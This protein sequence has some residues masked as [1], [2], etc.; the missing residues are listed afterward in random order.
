MTILLY[1]KR[2]P[3]F[4]RFFA[5]TAYITAA[6][7]AAGTAHAQTAGGYS[8]DGNKI[9]DPSGQVIEVRGV[10]WF[11]M[12]EGRGAPDGLN[13]SVLADMVAAIKGAGFNAIRIPFSVESINSP[14]PPT[15]IEPNKDM[16]N[17]DAIE[18]LNEVIDAAAAEGLLILLDVHRTPNGSSTDGGPPAG[19]EQEWIATWEKVATAFAD[20]PNVLGADLY[21]EP[22]KLCWGSDECDGDIGTDWAALAT[23]AGNAV[24]EIAPNWLIFVEGVTEYGGAATWWGGNLEGAREEPVELAVPNKLVYSPHEYGPEVWEQEWFKEPSARYSEGEKLEEAEFISDEIKETPFPEVMPYVWEQFW[25]YLHLEGTAPISVGEFGGKLADPI[26]LEWFTQL[27]AFMTEHKMSGFFWSWNSNSGD[28]GGIVKDI[29]SK[30]LELEEEKLSIMA[31]WLGQATGFSAFAPG[32]MPDITPGETPEDDGNGT[33]SDAGAGTGTDAP[34]EEPAGGGTSSEGDDAAAAGGGDDGCPDDGAPTLGVAGALA[35]EDEENAGAAPAGGGGD[36]YAKALDY[37]MRF[38]YSQQAGER[39][40][41]SD[42]Y[43]TY[44]ADLVESGDT[45]AAG[46]TGA[47]GYFDAGDHVKFV[48]PMAMAMYEL[49]AG[50]QRFA[51]GYEAAGQSDEIK[52]QLDHAYAFFSTLLDGDTL[53]AQVGDADADH[54]YW[55]GL[56]GVPEASGKPITVE[57]GGEAADMAAHLA[58]F[59]FRYGDTEKGLAFL[60]FA[61]DSLG[62]YKVP[63]FYETNHYQDELMLANLEAHHATGEETYLTRA[64][65]LSEEEY[66]D[67]G[68]QVTVGQGG[69]WAYDWDSAHAQA[70]LALLEY[71]PNYVA[72]AEEMLSGT[73]EKW[74][75]LEKVGGVMPFRLEWGAARYASNMASVMLQFGALSEA[76]AAYREQA[77]E[78]IDFVLGVHPEANGLSLMTGADQIIDGITQSPMNPHHR[79]A[80]MA[81]GEADQNKEGGGGDVLVGA[82]VG[83]P[84]PGQAYKDETGDYIMNEV[85]VDYNSGFTTALA[86]LTEG[87]DA[88]PTTPPAG[89]ATDDTEPDAGAETPAGA[90]P[91]APDTTTGDTGGADDDTSADGGAADDP[92]APQ[93][94]PPPPPEEVFDGCIFTDSAG[95]SYRSGGRGGASTNSPPNTPRPGRAEEAG[96]ESSPWVNAGPNV[97]ATAP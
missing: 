37:S 27:M 50:S 42:G 1:L 74:L 7:T 71:A 17:M 64:L 82:L 12:E 40:A 77:K 75:E 88:P 63:P 8:T 89:G 41:A 44:G 85:A 51:G 92:C 18:I 53:L 56:D 54:A 15:G 6:L 35:E 91:D 49:L 14:S 66:D 26:E 86:A 81:D 36:V 58:A 83:G 28:T 79:R 24:L 78:I 70:G 23:E 10:N 57:R 29:F 13:V 67:N 34:G 16:E 3:V 68:T 62:M 5:V 39:T 48:K 52:D 76:G 95:N 22:Y 90:A 93:T 69:W 65:E 33:D 55:G 59:M 20:K 73:I 31:D 87:G 80:D 43:A 11:G 30:D 60:E 46:G 32:E 72:E 97:D 84:G 94:A 96:T 19:S 25:A 61:E 38:Y 21:N 9:L 45:V 2:L 47:G 4:I